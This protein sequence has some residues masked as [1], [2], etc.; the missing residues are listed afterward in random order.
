MEISALGPHVHIL[1]LYTALERKLID[2]FHKIRCEHIN[3][4][5]IDTQKGF[6]EN[7]KKQLTLF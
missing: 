3:W 6:W 4:A 5:S 7:F 1:C 2:R